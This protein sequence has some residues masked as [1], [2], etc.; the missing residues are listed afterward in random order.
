MKRPLLSLRSLAMTTSLLSGVSVAQVPEDPDVFL[1][2]HSLVNFTMPLM[3]RGLIAASGDTGRVEAQ[4]M[5]G[6]SIL[7]NWENPTSAQGTPYTTALATGTYE[8]LVLT[9]AVPLLNHTRW[10][11]TYKA[12]SDF[13]G[14]ARTH[15]PDTRFYI[16]ETWHCINTGRTDTVIPAIAPRRCWYDNDDGLLWQ[17]RLVA[18]HAKWVKIVD[19]VKTL[20]NYPNAYLVPAGT[21]FSNLSLEIQAGRVPGIQS[22]RE[23][24]EDDIHPNRLGNWFVANVMFAT[25]RGR[26]PEGLGRVVNDEYGNRLLEVPQD[27]AAKLQQ[28]AWSTVCAEPLSG[29]RCATTAI[30]DAPRRRASMDLRVERLFDARGRLV[31]DPKGLAPVLRLAD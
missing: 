5:N 1:V 19:S 27:L 7:A 30:A 3:L 25:L 12:A 11:N 10:S 17:P 21:A 23:L 26:S 2:G 13:L 29:I 22:F 4:V 20:Q 8:A 28:V 14:F 15:R 24:F 9:E 16:Y 31:R 18:D 6:A